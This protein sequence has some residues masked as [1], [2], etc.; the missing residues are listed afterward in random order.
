MFKCDLCHYN[1]QKTE[2]GKTT[3]RV[4]VC[5]CWY[6]GVPFAKIQMGIKMV[7]KHKMSKGQQTFYKCITCKN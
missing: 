6:L 3:L 5:N 7:E 1:K 4:I 2:A